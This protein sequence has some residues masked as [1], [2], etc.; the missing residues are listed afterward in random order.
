MNDE[1][2]KQIRAEL[3]KLVGPDGCYVLMV[4]ESN[5]TSCWSDGNSRLKMRGLLEYG[6]DV[7]RDGLIGKPEMFDPDKN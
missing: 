1:M 6:Y 5:N 2:L 4:T 3:K 7:L